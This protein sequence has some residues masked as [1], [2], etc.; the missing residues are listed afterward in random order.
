MGLFSPDTAADAMKCVD[1]VNEEL[2]A[3]NAYVR[4]VGVTMYKDL[5]MEWRIQ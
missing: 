3:I 1:R 4:Q 5:S 2:K